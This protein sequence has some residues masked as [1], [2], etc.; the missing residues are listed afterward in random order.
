[1]SS[2]ITTLSPYDKRVALVAEAIT[3]N[4]NLDGD[5]AGELA[6]QVLRALNSIPEKVR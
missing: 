4:S 5:V 1:M 2:P 6:T 3:S